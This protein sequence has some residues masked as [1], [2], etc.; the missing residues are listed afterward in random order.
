MKSV[1]RK[2]S[3]G[4]TRR[5]AVRADVLETVERLL[6]EGESYTALGI[7]RISEEAG[8]S[9]SAFYLNFPD[10]AA[11]LVDLTEQATDELFAS[12]AGWI[13][14]DPQLEIE[15]LVENMLVSI[16]IFRTHKAV[17]AAFAEVA[18]YDQDVAGFWAT[19]MDE[20]VAALASRITAGQAAGTIR[21][22]LDPRVTASFVVW[23]AERA[24]SH[25]VATNPP[26]RD[27]SFAEGVA[28]SIWAMLFER[29]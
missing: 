12:S 5:D 15:S 1:T 14:E 28:K 19:R 3:T 2:T 18:A 6:R 11:L 21:A 17:L 10:K 16:R 25:H 22:E 20:L 8:V 9:R 13:S 23:G 7:A 29:S 24:V 27:R 26:S 4:R